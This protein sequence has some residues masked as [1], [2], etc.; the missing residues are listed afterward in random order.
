MDFLFG[1]A[2]SF[3]L[4][5]FLRPDQPSSLRKL[6]SDYGGWAYLH[7]TYLDGCQ[8]LSAGAGEDISFEVEFASAY[9]AKGWILDPTPRAKS[10]FESLKSRLGTARSQGYALGGN[11]PVEAYDLRNLE[12]SQ[13]EFVACALASQGTQ[14]QFFLPANEDHVSG[15]L[16][17]QLTSKEKV[18]RQQITVDTMRLWEF[19]EYHPEIS[20]VKLDIE[21]AELEVLGDSFSKID[22]VK[23]LLVEF[24]SLRGASSEIIRNVERLLG[25]LRL[26]GFHPRLVWGGFNT[27]FTR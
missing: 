11:Q 8:F 26:V 3:S 1:S 22:S 19:L 6:G 10:H 5:D 13:L 4:K 18:G 14:T 9:K 12:N 24:D 17:S 7:A 27:L 21:G 23:Q 16:G 25:D 20:I 2:K 15:Q